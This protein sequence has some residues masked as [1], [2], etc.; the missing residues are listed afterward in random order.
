MFLDYVRN[1]LPAAANVS[2]DL[3]LATVCDAALLT[4]PFARLGLVEVAFHVVSLRA[5]HSHV[6]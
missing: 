3:L 6:C 4:R 5:G 1:L 2:T